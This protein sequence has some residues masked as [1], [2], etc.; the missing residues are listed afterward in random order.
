MN[1]A[2]VLVNG[3]LMEKRFFDANLEEAKDLKWT[4][5][6]DSSSP[7]HRHC[8]VCMKSIS[9]QPLDEAYRSGTRYLCAYCH[10]HY[11]N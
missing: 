9:I 2:K 5:V 11:V 8:I 7:I 3:A 1:A 4:R 10:E 6:D